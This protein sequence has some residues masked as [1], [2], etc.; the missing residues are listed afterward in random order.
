[1]KEF[2]FEIITVFEIENGL[3]DLYPKY[4]QYVEKQIN[5]AFDRLLNGSQGFAVQETQIVDAFKGSKG[6]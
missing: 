1:M 5:V 4:M 3:K 6:E 2:N